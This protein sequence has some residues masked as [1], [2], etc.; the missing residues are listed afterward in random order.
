MSD[1]DAGRSQRCA[2]AIMAKAPSAGRV[3]TRLSPLLSPQEAMELGCRFLSDMTTNLA[4]AA[5]EAPIDPWIAF[6]PAGSESAFESIAAPGTRLVLADGSRA[7]PAGVEGFGTCLLQAAST[8]FDAGYGA[9]ALLNSDSPTLP[10]S[11][12]VEAAQFLLRPPARVVIGPSADGGYYLIG[13][14]RAHPELFRAID[15]STE[16]VAEQTRQRAFESGLEVL[17]LE[18]WFDVDDAGSL[19]RLM[20]ELAGCGAHRPLAYPAPATRAFLERNSF[21]DRLATPTA[22]KSTSSQHWA[23]TSSRTTRQAS[24]VGGTPT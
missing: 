10:T 17:D 24:G 15:W 5:R 13:M 11:H 7:A 18:A 23:E 21:A 22:G 19:Q 8:L 4:H 14:R 1:H 16:R 20:R 9:I 12:L 6:A 3:K 2:I